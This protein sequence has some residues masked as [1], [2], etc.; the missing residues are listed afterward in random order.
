MLNILLRC[1]NYTNY[2]TRRQVLRRVPPCKTNIA[3]ATNIASVRSK[4]SQPME[5]IVSFPSSLEP[6]HETPVL[7]NSKQHAVGYL[8]KILNARVYDTAIETQ[9]QEAK[10]LS[11]V[12]FCILLFSLF[13]SFLYCL[14]MGTN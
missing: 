2:A 14:L 7:L 8:S 13:V 10:S 3:I 12:R 9:L 1:T 4:S 5:E 6:N 11:M